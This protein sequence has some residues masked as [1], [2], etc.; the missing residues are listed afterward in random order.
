MPNLVSVQAQNAPGASRPTDPLRQGGSLQSGR[1]ARTQAENAPSAPQAK[2]SAPIQY[3]AASA[4][5]TVAQLAPFKPQNPFAGGVQRR[6]QPEPTPAASPQP[7]EPMPEPTFRPVEPQE[8]ED[9]IVELPEHRLR[10]AENL[11]TG[12]IPQEP[13]KQQEQDSSGLLGAAAQLAALGAAIFLVKYSSLPY[14]MGLKK[15]L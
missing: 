6:V 11:P 8:T 7:S 1:A 13:K 12:H 4:G 9:D 2:P 5:G 3:L 14:L 15:K 10:P